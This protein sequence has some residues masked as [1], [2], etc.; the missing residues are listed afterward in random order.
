MVPQSDP[1]ANFPELFAEV[2]VLLYTRNT[3]IGTVF[4]ASL[5][6]YSFARLRFGGRD[7]VFS[8]LLDNV[9][10]HKPKPD[11]WLSRHPNVHLHCTPTHTSWFNQIECWFSILAGATLKGAS[12]TSAQQ[13]RDAIDRFVEAPQLPL[14]CALT[15]SYFAGY[16]PHVE[17]LIRVGE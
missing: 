9:N 13:L 10:T 4:S 2:P 1:L 12:F 11:L 16:V 14:D 5:A 8:V 15:G 3:L 6:G 7:L 17:G